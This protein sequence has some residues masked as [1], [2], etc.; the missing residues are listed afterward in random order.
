MNVVPL[1]N[2][3]GLSEIMV[4]SNVNERILIEE[5]NQRVL[6]QTLEGIELVVILKQENA[7]NFL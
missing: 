7:C 6:A 5:T 4:E 1:A 2:D 3:I